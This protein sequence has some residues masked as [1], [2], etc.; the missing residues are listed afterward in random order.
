MSRR[1][2]T[3]KFIKDVLNDKYALVIGNE[4][5]LDT[6]IEPTGDVHNYF[7]KKVNENSG[8]QYDDYYDIALEKSER[9]N[10]IRQLIENEDVCFKAEYV[11]PLLTKLLETKLFT[12][13]LT[14][15]TDGFLEAAMRKVWG[16]DLQVV[17]IYDKRTVDGLQAELRN[18]RRGRCRRY[19]F[20]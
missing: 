6:K 9:I 7:L 5:L 19:C 1:F 18:C 4:I 15:T 20:C 10:P 13:V 14:T 12:T 11:S 17:N 2:N 16:K 8:V 3:K